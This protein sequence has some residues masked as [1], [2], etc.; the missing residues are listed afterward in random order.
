MNIV[1]SK[2]IVVIGGN[3][4]QLHKTVEDDLVKG[5]SLEFRKIKVI[6]FLLISIQFNEAL[7][8][9]KPFSKT[10]TF[11]QKTIGSEGFHAALWWETPKL[12]ENISSQISEMS[13]FNQVPRTSKLYQ[14]LNKSIKK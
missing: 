2:E 14:F 8:F 13:S 7:Y 4:Y 12:I 3:K 1:D 9:Y 5:T 11:S 10:M 6:P